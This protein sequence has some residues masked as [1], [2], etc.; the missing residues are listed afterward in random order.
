[1]KKL[2]HTKLWGMVGTSCAVCPDPKP[3]IDEFEEVLRDYCTS[4]S[5]L[6]ERTRTLEYAR[7]VLRVHLEYPD[8]GAGKKCTA[9]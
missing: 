6:A 2:D 8:T 1:M 4:E 3:V 7:A 9:A 5:N